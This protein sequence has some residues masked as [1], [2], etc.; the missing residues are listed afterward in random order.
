MH[1]ITCIGRDSVERRFVFDEPDD[2]ITPDGH[3]EL[4]FCVKTHPEAMWFFE[5]QLREKPDGEFQI[6]SIQHHHRPE[7]ASTGIPDS[8]LPYLTRHLGQRICSSR[9]RVQ[10]TNEYRTVQATGMWDRLVQ[11]GLA[12]FSAGEGIYRTTE[13]GAAPNGGP[14]RPVGNSGDTEGP[15]SVS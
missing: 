3:R 10:G 9:G 15:P 4:F 13:P 7:Y 5:L 12:Q 2:E 6:I 14:A 1:S 11:K 8:L